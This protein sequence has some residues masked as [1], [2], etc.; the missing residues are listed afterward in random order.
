MDLKDMFNGN[1]A[2]NDKYAAF[3]KSQS[4]FSSGAGK[5]TQGRVS[6]KRYKMTAGDALMVLPVMIHLPISIADGSMLNE[7]I[8][9]IGHFSTI[10]RYIKQKCLSNQLFSSNLKVVLGEE[11][12]NKIDFNSDTVSNIERKEIF[13]K[14]RQPLVYAKT[15]IAVKDAQSGAS[16]AR[17]FAVELAVDPETGDFIDD[18]ANPMIYKL[19]RL[20]AACIGAKIKKLRMDNDAAGDAKRTEN[21]IKKSCEAMWDARC[22]SNPYT[23]GTTRVLMFPT[24]K[25]Y[26]IHPDIRSNWAADESGI[27][28]YEWYMK[29]NR[30]TVEAT[31]EMIGTKRDIYEDFL[32]IRQQTPSFTNA[33]IMQRAREITRAIAGTDDNIYEMLPKFE[34]AYAN[35]RDNFE[36]WDEKIIKSSA[37]E[38]K[39]ISDKNISAIFKNNMS[40]LV[41]A[42]KSQEVYGAY[43]DVIAELDTELSDKMLQAAMN[44][45]LETVG[46]I[47]KELAEAPV[48]TEETPGYGGEE[49]TADDAEAMMDAL[50]SDT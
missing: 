6:L 15:V 43:E 25:D 42:M 45:E 31:Q 16:F 9:Y 49:E 24:N 37:F 40:A 2:L 41:T 5:V 22:L 46:D 33:D 34:E 29:I 13:W 17:P 39:T 28:K 38:Y 32:L 10:V 7:A 36:L 27:R 44:S 12:F 26:E 50:T 4:N 23:L 19:Y 48:I 47:T 18:P 3:A 1:S 30:R 21:D 20:E 35:Y 14:F 11:L 8:P